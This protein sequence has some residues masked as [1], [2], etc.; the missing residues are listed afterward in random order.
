MAGYLPAPSKHVPLGTENPPA[1]IMLRFVSH[2]IDKAPEVF[3]HTLASTATFGKAFSPETF[4][5]APNGGM[6]IVRR[7]TSNLDGCKSWSVPFPEGESVAE[8]GEGLG[9]L[10]TE[11]IAR[12]GAILL[13]DRGDCTFFDKA[14]NAL[15]GGAAGI[16]IVG[17]PPAGSTPLNDQR[18]GNVGD[19]GLIRPS[20][21]G[22]APALVEVLRMAEFGVAYVQWAAGEVIKAALQQ[23]GV[24]VEVLL[25]DDGLSPGSVTAQGAMPGRSVGGEKGGEVREGRVMVADHLVGNLR[26]IEHP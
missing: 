15:K 4:E 21:E 23:G 12:Q 13:I 26:I 14:L 25:L 2:S 7:E 11:F 5:F 24:G 22:E 20:A 19:E 17:Y 18:G 8:E 9:T 1:E 10:A 6:T 3:L 16:I